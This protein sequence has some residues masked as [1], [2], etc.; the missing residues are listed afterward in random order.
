ME[1]GGDQEFGGRR[2]HIERISMWTVLASAGPSQWRRSRTATW[3]H[4]V[5][6]VMGVIAQFGSHGS[7]NTDVVAGLVVRVLC[8]GTSWTSAQGDDAGRR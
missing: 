2:S 8:G 7:I 4:W 1:G 6:G 5:A 3:L